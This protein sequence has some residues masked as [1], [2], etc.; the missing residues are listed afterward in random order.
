MYVVVKLQEQN[1][2]KY[3]ALRIMPIKYTKFALYKWQLLQRHVHSPNLFI[4][5]SEI[6]IDSLPLP[7]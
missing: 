1:C 3:C 7:D 4:S 2:N 5:Q 6:R